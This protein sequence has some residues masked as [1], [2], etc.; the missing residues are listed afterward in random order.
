MFVCWHVLADYIP[1]LLAIHV[2]MSHLPASSNLLYF[3][4]YIRILRWIFRPWIDAT[5]LVRHAQ[6]MFIGW[7]HHI[8]LRY[9]SVICIFRFVAWPTLRFTHFFDIAGA[10]HQE[11]FWEVETGARGDREGTV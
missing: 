9:G 6:C 7:Q 3:S 11:S 1:G 10:D 4:S 2:S 5:G 8:L